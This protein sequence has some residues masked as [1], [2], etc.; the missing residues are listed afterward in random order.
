MILQE[1]NMLSVA[2]I[3][4]LLLIGAMIGMVI[5]TLLFNLFLKIRKR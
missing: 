5:W 3:G 2:L 4:A 1:W